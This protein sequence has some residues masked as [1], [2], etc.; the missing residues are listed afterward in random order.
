MIIL[1]NGNVFRSGGEVD[2]D[3]NRL[4]WSTCQKYHNV[5]ASGFINIIHPLVQNQPDI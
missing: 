3:A 4:H 2:M 5:H 1:V